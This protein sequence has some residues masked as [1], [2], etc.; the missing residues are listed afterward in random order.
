MPDDKIL[1]ST[2]YPEYIPVKYESD[3]LL[4]K[5]WADPSINDV[6]FKP[7]FN[8]VDGNVNRVSHLGIYTLAENGHPLNP[9]GR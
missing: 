5:S 1:W 7:Q 8:I 6:S 3:V 9:C 2:S 4:G